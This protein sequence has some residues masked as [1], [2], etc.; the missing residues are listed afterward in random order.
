M[1]KLIK[2]FREKP[3][4]ANRSNLENYLYKHAMAVCMASD[5]DIA[6]LRAHSFV[7]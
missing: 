7:S 4:A 6:F 2:T 3:T 5:E 1:A